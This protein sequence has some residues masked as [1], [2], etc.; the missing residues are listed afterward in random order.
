M[1]VFYVLWRKETRICQQNCFFDMI[2]NG[3]GPLSCS[4]LDVFDKKHVEFSDNACFT[5]GN[6]RSELFSC[7]SLYLSISLILLMKLNTSLPVQLC[8]YEEV[9]PVAP[10]LA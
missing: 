4:E 10:V 1:T 7:G 3:I 5:D 9:R 8:F 2:V 6:P